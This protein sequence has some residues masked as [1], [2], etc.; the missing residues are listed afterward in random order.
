[1]ILRAPPT[2]PLDPALAGP[3]A[4]GI[5]PPPPHGDA[6]LKVLLLDD[7]EDFRDV[8]RDYLVSRLYKVTEVSNGA[9]GLRAIMRDTYDLIICDMLM[10]K[11]GG[12]RF[13]WAVT[14]VRPAARLRFVFITG[15][16]HDPKV[17]HFFRRVQATVLVKPFKLD[18]LNASLLDIDR[19]LR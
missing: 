13:Y 15:H 18:D 11:V 5:E 6:P 3:T 2:E 7:Q 16:Q 10:P 9:E 12:E 14:R 19:K 1:M 8:I 17:D 4:P